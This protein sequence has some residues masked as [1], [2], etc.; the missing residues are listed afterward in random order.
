MH[1]QAYHHPVTASTSSLNVDH[2]N[3]NLAT[4]VNQEVYQ[5]LN[6]EHEII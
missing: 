1:L 6:Y 4:V 5:A 2:K 3:I